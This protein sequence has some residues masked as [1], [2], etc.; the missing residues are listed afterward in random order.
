MNYAERSEGFGGGFGTVSG[1]AAAWSGANITRVVTGSSDVPAVGAAV[2]P[3]DAPQESSH[4]NMTHIARH[5]SA[6]IA[7]GI[8]NAHRRTTAV[9]TQTTQRF[10][11]MDYSIP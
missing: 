9:A 7:S 8:N 3:E 4:T 10:I 6:A 2:V 11:C 1:T 5:G